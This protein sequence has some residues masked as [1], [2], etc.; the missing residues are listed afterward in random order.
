[1]KKMK[2]NNINDSIKEI[3][4]IL[5]KNYFHTCIEV[6]NNGVI[7]WQVFYK[8]L[9]E[10]MYY[11]SKNK[12]LLTSENDGISDIY[13]L[14]DRFEKEKHKELIKNYKEI[15]PL[16]S[17]MYK[18]M[19]GITKNF[20]E[21]AIIVI[22]FINIITLINMLIIHNIVLSITVLITIISLGLFSI[23]FHNKNLKII[24][25]TNQKINEIYIRQ[26]IRNQGLYF[27][28]KIR[29]KYE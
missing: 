24:N 23:H 5:D 10:K 22:L 1:M 28:E 29:R 13:L 21:Y 19:C 2:K 17:E 7:S 11:S 16:G 18:T 8:N 12:P 9:P 4:T 6:Q 20:S 27:V 26:K 3:K 15:L 14:R 25:K